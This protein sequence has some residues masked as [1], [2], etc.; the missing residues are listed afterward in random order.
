MSLAS[1]MRSLGGVD[2]IVCEENQDTD[3]RYLGA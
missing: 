1:C 3:R 2:G